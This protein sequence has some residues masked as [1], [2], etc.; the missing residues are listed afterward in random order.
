M[1]YTILLLHYQLSKQMRNTCMVD[2]MD[3]IPHSYV[4]TRFLHTSFLFSKQYALAVHSF[5]TYLFSI[6]LIPKSTYVHT[7]SFGFLY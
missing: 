1:P 4:N 6:L 7:Q 3:K 5:L 2:G